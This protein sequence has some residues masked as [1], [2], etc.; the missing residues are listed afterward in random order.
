[1]AKWQLGWRLHSNIQLKIHPINTETL[2]ACRQ[3]RPSRRIFPVPRNG[4]GFIIL[5]T[6]THLKRYPPQGWEQ[7]KKTAMQQAQV[8][9]EVW[10]RT[11]SANL[12]DTRSCG[13]RLYI[14]MGPAGAMRQ[15]ELPRHK[16]HQQ[17]FS[18]CGALFWSH[19]CSAVYE[20]ATLHS[21]WEAAPAAENGSTMK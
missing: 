2:P 12:G 1:M 21:R 20:A 18:S 3:V 15:S 8:R 14:S 4:N 13:C 9:S 19:C 5:T 17:L 7:R 10:H 11:K 16:K 6:S